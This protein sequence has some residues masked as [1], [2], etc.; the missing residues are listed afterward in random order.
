MFRDSIIY[1]KYKA[2][3][4]AEV[5]YEEGIWAFG[6]KLFSHIAE[7]ICC[8][9]AILQIE[10]FN[11]HKHAS[12]ELVDFSYNKCCKLIRPIQDEKEIIR[13]L[14]ILKNIKLNTIL[15]IGTSHGGTLFLLSHIASVDALIVSIDIPYKD[16]GGGYSPWRTRLYKSFA[17][18]GQ[19]ICLIRG[20]SHDNKV[21]QRLRAILYEDKIDFLFIDGDHSYN[22]VKEDF[23]TYG[24]LVKNGGMIAFHDIILNK[25]NPQFEAYKYWAEIKHKYEHTEIVI[26]GQRNGIGL[27]KI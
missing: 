3:R 20:S 14:E 8:P 19:E 7:I 23:E 1:Y 4:A 2:Q 27:I 13:F 12:N 5:L 9:F 25:E 26:G 17:L 15:E 11:R 6:K 21:K 22:G 24:P 10:D 18:P 16:F